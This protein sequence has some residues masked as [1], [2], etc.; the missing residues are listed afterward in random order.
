[1][2]DI[3]L[4]VLEVLERTGIKVHS[5]EGLTA[6][7]KQEPRWKEIEFGFLLILWKRQSGGLLGVWH[8]AI[9]MEAGPYCSRI[10]RSITGQALIVPPFE[11]P[12]PERSGGFSRRI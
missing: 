10:T 3:H 4:A 5:E 9:V 2:E 11:T 1:M 12:L 7:G 6:Y 8:S